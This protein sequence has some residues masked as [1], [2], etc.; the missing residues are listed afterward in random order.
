[1]PLS[2]RS[3][4]RSDVGLI[5]EGNEDS[6]YASSRLLIVA[7]GMGGHAAGELASA[8]AIATLAVV[9]SDEPTD[10]SIMDE[11]DGALL[12]VGDRIHEIITIEPD[13]TGMGT[14][15]TAAYWLG[16]A[17]A[18]AHVGDS[19]A[20]LLRDGE[21]TQLTHD[22]TYVQT[23]IDAG[24]ISEEDAKVHPRRSLLM[25]A[26]DGL[27]PVEPDLF[28]QELREGDRVLLCTDGL[29]GVVP[30]DLIQAVL[31]T[32]D[33]TGTVTAL[34]DLALERGA[35]DN[36]TVVVADVIET[37][38]ASGDSAPVVVGAAGETRVRLRLPGIAFPQDSQPD[39]DR[40][41][42]PPAVQ[43]P[44]TAPQQ[45]IDANIVVP[46][47]AK[48][49]DA[50][51]RAD[52]SRQRNRIL[53]ASGV[54][55]VL[56]VAV[57][58]ASLLIA[59]SWLSNRWYVGLEGSAG[60]G[61]VA[62]YQGTDQT[63]MGVELSTLY[64]DSGITIGSLPYFDQELVSKTIAAADMADAQRIIGELQRKATECQTLPIPTGCPGALE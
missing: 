32:G 60:T 50:Q 54:A 14:T 47:S 12:E 5:R 62:I 2:L 40:P 49:R 59:S 16:D 43:G 21:L 26:L 30:G 27:M 45:V 3:A 64:Q 42:V 51:A 35:P 9:E 18:L 31:S 17:I 7:D 37:S 1:M 24:R 33:P 63:L 6:G 38:D 25:R 10:A 53:I 15:V 28:T 55:I 36:V 41:D 11:F 4:A 29:S 22:H 44:P 61:T 19:R 8:T 46:A 48:A 58:V 39:P 23:L 20:Y 13:L 52:R 34:V 57:I 56:V